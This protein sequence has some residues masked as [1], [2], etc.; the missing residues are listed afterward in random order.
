MKFRLQLALLL[1][2]LSVTI[3]SAQ[4]KSKDEKALEKEWKKKMSALDPMEYKRLVEENA[5]V[6]AEMSEINS[7]VSGFQNEINA[8]NTELGQLKG[9]VEDLKKKTADEVASNVT[10]TG[11]AAKKAGAKGVVYKVQIGSFRNRDLA[12]YLDNNPNFGGDVDA[13]GTKK[14]TLGYFGDY[15]EADTFKK[16]L[17]EMG[18]KDAWIVAYKNGQR[19][20]IKDVLE[21]AI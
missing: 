19:V 6:R 10:S 17:R 21:G 13:D 4:K 12:K 14:Y 18:V 7:K 2:V 1:M 15:W 3:A 11:S 9:Q 8:K 16:Y 20:D 5:T